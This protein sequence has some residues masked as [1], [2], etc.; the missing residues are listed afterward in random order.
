[1]VII[2]K[3]Y[4]LFSVNIALGLTGAMQVGRILHYQSS[5]EF[6]AKQ[7]SQKNQ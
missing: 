2:P 7:E 4:V 5:D 6:K 3:N 1:M